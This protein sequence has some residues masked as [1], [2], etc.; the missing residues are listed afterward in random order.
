MH[1]NLLRVLDCC[2][3]LL[4]SHLREEPRTTTQSKNVVAFSL[5]L[6]K[7]EEGEEA[8]RL[9][10]AGSSFITAIDPSFLSSKQLVFLFSPCL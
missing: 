6:K 1:T 2:F 9:K 8:A 10:T 4:L 3:L 5:W 7:K